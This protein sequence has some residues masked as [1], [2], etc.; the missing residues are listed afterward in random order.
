MANM[1]V[2]ASALNVRSGPSTSHSKLKLLSRGAKI[3]TV[4]SQGGWHKL[5]TGG[6][7][8][9]KHVKKINN[10]TTNAS[11]NKNMTVTASVLNIRSGPGKNNSVTGKLDRG[12]T[13]TT[14]RE[15][16]G[17]S[18]LSQGG[19]VYNKHLTPTSTTSQAK[20]AADAA[21]AAEIRTIE[22]RKRYSIQDHDFKI[23]GVEPVKRMNN[24]FNMPYQYLPTVDNRVSGSDYG[25][26]FSE[27]IINDLP[28]ATFKMGLP[29][30]LSNT[31]KDLKKNALNAILRGKASVLQSIVAEGNIDTRYYS[32]KEDHTAYMSH[33]TALCRQSASYMGLGKEY[34][35]KNYDYETRRNNTTNLLFGA[36]R[37]VTFYI[38]TATSAD[39]SMNNSTGDSMLSGAVNSATD[40]AKEAEFILGAGA[41]MDVDASSTEAYNETI[42]KLTSGAMSKN[43][44]SIG[45]KVSNFVNTIKMGGN[46]I[47]PEIWKESN[48][49]KSYTIKMKLKA[50]YGTK[51]CIFND[52][53]VPFY[54]ILAMTLPRSL[55]PNGYT[56]P[57]LVRAY[58]KGWFNCE[59]GI[60]DSISFTKGGDGDMW[61]FEGLPTQIDVEITI[62]DLYSVMAMTSDVKLGAFTSN[63]PLLDFLSTMSGVNLTEE[64]MD[65]E[66]MSIVHRIKAATKDIPKNIYLQL[67]DM[68]YRNIDRMPLIGS[69]VHPRY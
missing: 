49:S 59:M 56:S 17:W 45:A 64:P 66:I 18:Q 32:F 25:R 24:I 44:N 39:E 47:F 42:A 57:F 43:P 2:T 26:K 52:I 53:L 30:F 58:S 16:N 68:I 14:V 62:K 29:V 55:S 36:R 6:W 63:L 23:I 33:V 50:P 21:K 1:E 51:E 9:G 60:V 69:M 13:V 11:S 48:Y 34:Y 20:A 54:H 15:Q 3:T 38:D 46:L 35:E 12:S 7:V 22:L 31:T 19:W 41:G 5:S 65:R 61:S 28:I 40:L 10:N 67:D 8:S 4:E 27:T 37:N